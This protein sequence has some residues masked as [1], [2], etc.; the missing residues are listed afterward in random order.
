MKIRKADIVIV[1]SGPG[2]A[3][4]A[5][6]LTLKN[7]NVVIIEQGKDIPPKGTVFSAFNYV[8]GLSCLGKGFILTKEGFQIIRG[9][10][11]GGSSMLYLGSAWEP[12]FKLF[13]K[14]DIDLQ[15]QTKDIKKE[16]KIQ[17][18]PDH[19]VGPRAKEITQSAL[20]LGYEWKKIPKFLKADHCIEN[21]N[22]CMFGCPNNAK[23]H[24]RDWVMDAV[25]HGARLYNQMR[26]KKVIVDNQ[27]AIGVI[28]V[29]QYGQDIQIQSNGVVLSAGGIGSPS[30]L[31]RSGINEAGES[32]FFDPFIQVIGHMKKEFQPSHEFPMVT[33]IH[34]EDQGIMITDMPTPFSIY[35]N[36]VLFALKP[37][38]IFS[39][40]TSIG[41]LVKIK[42]DICGKITKDDKIM[43]K[44]LTNNDLQKFENGKVISQNILKHLGA[45]D[46]WA[47]K[48][49]AA[50]PG[51]TCRIGH[52]V[53]KNL[54]TR[55]KNLFVVDASVIPE[56]W[57]LPPTLT[58]ISLA[59]RLTNYIQEVL[60]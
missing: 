19:L 58:I 53:N 31:K 12:P 14:Y 18:V 13:E 39:I 3:T 25:Q 2:G 56:P 1:G 40:G 23:W 37:K 43:S 36:N 29:D 55:Y 60:P 20:A 47:T 22:R 28:A 34:L 11:T 21:C 45:S 30:V 44:P 50:H 42:D 6:D 46:I 57:G 7:K 41:L 51:G 54:E 27:Q 5:R 8:G 4:V 49:S 48:V 32:F 26:C 38:H 52:I 24:A 10:T 59:R 17:T 9:V 15:T 16:L 35:A 33:G